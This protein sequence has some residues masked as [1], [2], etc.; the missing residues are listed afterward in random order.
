M[1]PIRVLVVDDSVV[2]RR[3]VSDVLAS[4]P[5]I[6][7]VGTAI[8]GRAALAK[9]PLLNPDI[10]TLDIEMPEMDGLATLRELRKTNPRLPVVMFSTLTERGAAATLEALAVGANDYVTKPANMGSIAE[11]IASVREQLL[12][13][14]RALTGRKPIHGAAGVPAERVATSQHIARPAAARSGPK[15]TPRV[16][17][18]GCSTGGP[19]ALSAVLQALPAS[20]PVPV[21]VVQHMP[22]V[23]TTQFAARLDRLCALRVLEVQGGEALAAGTVYLA[24]GNFHLEVGGKPGAPVTARLNSGPQVSFCRPAVDVLF[25]SVAAT[26]QAAALAVVLTGMGHDG[27]DGCA[28]I[29]G[30]GGQ[31]I[32]QDAETSVVWGMPG[33]VAGAGL[34]DQILPL[35]RIAEAIGKVLGSQSGSNTLAGAAGAKR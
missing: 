13:R 11:S 28:R 14:V 17:A 22:P 25:A 34:A 12:P 1:R 6:E 4:D 10:L 33:A 20:L 23:F 30:N 32:V 35:P 18:I 7:V 15:V 31:I 24:P 5:D 27:R 9:I 21:V 29:H 26:Y 2:I 16:L 8:N 3:M 19:Q